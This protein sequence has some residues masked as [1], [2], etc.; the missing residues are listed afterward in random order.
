MNMAWSRF[1]A[2]KNAIIDIKKDIIVLMLI[3]G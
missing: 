3:H 2:N 1:H